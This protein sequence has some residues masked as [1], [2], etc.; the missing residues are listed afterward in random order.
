MR[1]ELVFF[2]HSLKIKGKNLSRFD[3]GLYIYIKKN[4]VG[5][6]LLKEFKQKKK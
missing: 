5:Y 6:S 1:G 4:A 3:W 2:S